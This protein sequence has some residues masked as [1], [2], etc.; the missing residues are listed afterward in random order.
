MAN[1]LPVIVAKGDGTQDDLVRVENGWQIEPGNYGALVEA[2]RLALSDPQR[3]R[4]MGEESY[5]I[6]SEEINLE[7]MVEVFAGALNR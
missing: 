2:M 1:G 7:K 6:V 4:K 3:L 5:R